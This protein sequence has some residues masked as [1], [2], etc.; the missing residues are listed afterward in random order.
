M[1]FENSVIKVLQQR[2][3]LFHREFAYYMLAAKRCNSAGLVSEISLRIL[4]R[5][6]HMRRMLIPPRL[7]EK[8]N[9]VGNM[10]NISE[11]SSFYMHIT[12]RVQRELASSTESDCESP[13]INNCWK[14]RKWPS[15][16]TVRLS[17]I[18]HPTE[19]A[20]CNSHRLNNKRHLLNTLGY[21]RN[22]TVEREVTEIPKSQ[23][24][25]AA[26]PTVSGFHISRRTLEMA[27][28][29]SLPYLRRPYTVSK[30]LLS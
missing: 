17:P 2:N 19:G 3:T 10:T 4:C 1:I 26:S 18:P 5:I 22:W 8:T 11:Y 23:R 20:L 7:F 24:Q 28:H 13:N 29:R 9:K 30:L 15:L 16:E 27:Y 25:P 14:Q 6:F 12:D 21:M